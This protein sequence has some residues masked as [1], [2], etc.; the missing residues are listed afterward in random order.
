MTAISRLGNA[1]V[2]DSLSSFLRPSKLYHHTEIRNVFATR[3]VQR[4]GSRSK[5]GMNIK[6][7][8]KPEFKLE[9]ENLP[10]SIPVRPPSHLWRALGFTAVVFMI[11]FSGSRGYKF[12][13]APALSPM[14]QFLSLGVTS[15]RMTTY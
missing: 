3:S 8:M 9:V 15:R 7:A 13:L 12:S 1:L 14:H 11:G 6:K 5:F 10:D 4:F 2:L